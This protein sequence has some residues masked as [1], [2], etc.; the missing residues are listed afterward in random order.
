MDTIQ[1]MLRALNDGYDHST[2]QKIHDDLLIHNKQVKTMCSIA[3]GLKHMESTAMEDHLTE[4]MKFATELETIGEVFVSSVY[5]VPCM[6][7]RM[8]VIRD[9]MLAGLYV[10]TYGAIF[11]IRLTEGCQSVRNKRA[12]EKH[13]M[14]ELVKLFLGF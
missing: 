12:S 3:Q 7:V 11:G 10:C 14:C 13:L 8:F 9:G 4:L 1:H 6:Y 5:D 2:Y